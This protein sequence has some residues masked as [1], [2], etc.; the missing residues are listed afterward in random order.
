MGVEQGLQGMWRLIPVHVRAAED[1]ERRAEVI[2]EKYHQS[3][4]NV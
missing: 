3:L 2:Y 4:L 1:T